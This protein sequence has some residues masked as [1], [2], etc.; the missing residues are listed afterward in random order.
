APKKVKRASC[1]FCI[2]NINLVKNYMDTSMLSPSDS[3]KRQREI[4]LTSKSI[5]TVYNIRN[6]SPIT[7]TNI[8]VLSNEVNALRKQALELNDSE[9]ITELENLSQTINLSK[10]MINPDSLC[11]NSNKELY[12]VLIESNHSSIGK[13][14]PTNI[15]IFANMITVNLY[16]RP[17]IQ[18]F[19]CL[20]YGDTK[21]N[22]RSKKSK[23]RNCGEERTSENDHT[24][25][26]CKNE[27]IC[28]HCKG[29]HATTDRKCP[30]YK[31]QQEISKLMALDNL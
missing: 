5:K 2:L 26:N 9:L 13:Q 28:I 10:K 21:M 14:L 19:K 22:C 1:E 8:I 29:N 17:V 25:E 31:I 23:C 12:I 4:N 20:R 11:S 3:P 15:A 7:F 18:C 24:E 27:T 6:K 30:E 16:I